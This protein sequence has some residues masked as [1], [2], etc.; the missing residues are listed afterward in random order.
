LF[1]PE[2]RYYKYDFFFDNCSTRISALL[3]QVLGD[4]VSFLPLLKANTY[5]YRQLIDKQ[6][7]ASQP[8]SDFGID[9]AL[10]VKIDK[11]TTSEEMQFL[12]KYLEESLSLA[13]KNGQPLVLATNELVRGETR[14]SIKY[15]GTLPSTVT[16]SIFIIG[17]LIHIFNLKSLAQVYDSLFLFII[18]ILGIVVI[19]L[20]FF[21][22][23]QPTKINY[24]L[25]WANP[26]YLVM[27]VVFFVKAN[28]AKVFYAVTAFYAFGI[29]L[30]WIAL[31]Q[32]LNPAVR[33]FILLQ[34]LI[35]YYW[36][37]NFKVKIIT[38]NNL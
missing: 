2:N 37:K 4:D 6:V 22:D 8:W 20:W 31:P 28:W 38:D 35:S 16:W 18:S 26:L 3:R 33:P 13:T 17:L 9:L 34:V 1:K 21:T 32:E 12:P 23:H 30:F 14:K 25:L 27:I 5:S 29:I 15:E 36:F 24:N 19:F 7:S 10:G 11:V